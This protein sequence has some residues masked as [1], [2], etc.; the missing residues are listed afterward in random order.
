[1]GNSVICEKTLLGAGTPN[2]MCILGACHQI[3]QLM[4]LGKNKKSKNIVLI[5]QKLWP[6]ENSSSG[7]FTGLSGKIFGRPKIWLLLHF[8]EQIIKKRLQMTL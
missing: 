5:G 7:R 3:Y 8:L 6:P 1:M 2:L 4:G